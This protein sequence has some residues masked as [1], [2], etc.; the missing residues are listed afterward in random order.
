VALFALVEYWNQPDRFT[1]LN[2]ASSEGEAAPLAP[3]DPLSSVDDPIVDDFAIDNTNPFAEGSE[4]DAFSPS[5][6]REFA[7]SDA[8]LS[9]TNELNTLDRTVDRVLATVRLD[10]LPVPSITHSSFSFSASELPASETQRSSEVPFYRR[11]LR[12]PLRT[13]DSHQI[14]DS[15]HQ[16]Q[17]TSTPLQSALDR[18]VARSREPITSSASTLTDTEPVPSSNTLPDTI[19]SVRDEGNSISTPLQLNRTYSPQPLPGQPSTQQ[20]F[21]PPVYLPQ[22][23][24]APG[25]TGYTLPA[26]LSVPAN[27][28]MRSSQTILPPQSPSLQL[29]LRP[30]TLPSTIQSETFGTVVQPSFQ[31]E[32]TPFSIPRTPPNQAIGGGQINT[33]SNP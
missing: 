11:S 3:L 2:S 9:S 10:S 30:A 21:P 4:L 17:A 28:A 16:A 22:T 5:P 19:G 32:P 23:A 6:G 26:T 14:L 31:S 29:Q 12:S 27:G 20:T 8:I 1:A 25:T 15:K 13:V 7:F 18:Q 24:P 33:F